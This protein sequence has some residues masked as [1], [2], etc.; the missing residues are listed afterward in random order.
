[1]NS[2][3]SVS[4]DPFSFKKVHTFLRLQAGL[5]VNSVYY[6]PIEFFFFC[7]LFLLSFLLLFSVL[8]IK[9]RSLNMPFGVCFKATAIP[10]VHLIILYLMLLY[11]KNCVKV[12]EKIFKTK[13]FL[14][15]Q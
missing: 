11:C 6:L 1:M 3:S 15:V 12:E 9:A 5:E 10:P 2:C 13:R 7:I 4:L 14:L 8:D